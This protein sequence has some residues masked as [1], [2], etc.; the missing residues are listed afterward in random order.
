MKRRPYQIIKH[1]KQFVGNRRRIAWVCLIIL[2]GWSLNYQ[3]QKWVCNQFFMKPF[4]MLISGGLRD[5]ISC[6]RSIFFV[7]FLKKWKYELTGQLLYWHFCM[8]M[9]KI[10]YRYTA[11]YKLR[12]LS[13][14]MAPHITVQK[15]KHQTKKESLARDS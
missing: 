7:L 5:K 12:I 1:S 8:L 15:F 14:K 9:I 4:T 10:L 3:I 6:R 13:A 11:L 2:W